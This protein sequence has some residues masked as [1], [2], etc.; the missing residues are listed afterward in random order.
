MQNCKIYT[1]S[2]VHKCLV[3]NHDNEDNHSYEDEKTMIPNYLTKFYQSTNKYTV[4]TYHMCWKKEGFI[5]KE[6][7]RKNDE[8]MMETLVQ[9]EKPP[10]SWKK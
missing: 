7:K 10:F 1:Q 6:I 3:L 2:K 5:S 9:G 8:K 4:G